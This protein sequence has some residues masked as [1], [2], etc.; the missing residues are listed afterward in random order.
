MALSSKDPSEIIT[1]TFDFSALLTVPSNPVMTVV[2][3]GGGLDASPSAMLSGVPTISGATVMQKY[4][5]GQSG[6]TYDLKCQVDAP[7]GSRYLLHD[8]L[9]VLAQ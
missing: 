8:Y 7:D 9:P 6:T 2:W 3:N 5:G 4:I 1:V